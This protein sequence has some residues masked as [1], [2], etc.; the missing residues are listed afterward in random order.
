MSHDA[1]L[2]N[3]AASIMPGGPASLTEYFVHGGAIS[4]QHWRLT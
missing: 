2:R 1:R 3:L 4:F